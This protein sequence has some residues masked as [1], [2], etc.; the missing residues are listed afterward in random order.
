MA[1]AALLRMR[2]GHARMGL[3]LAGALMAAA[4]SSGG[5]APATSSIA[6]TSTTTTAA[7]TTTTAVPTTTS[8]SATT[9]T[10]A[11]LSTTTTGA[12]PTTTTTTLPA[13]WRPVGAEDPLRVWVF[14]DSLAGPV[15]NALARLASAR[16]VVITTIDFLS[17]SG[18]ASPAFYDW[19]EFVAWRLP[20]VAPDVVVTVLGANDGQGMSTAQGWL[21]Y[22]TPEWDAEY[23]ARVG[24]FM[25]QLLT[26][27][28]RVYWVR[29]PIMENPYYDQRIRHMNA[30]IRQQA[31]LRLGIRS[32]EAYTLF[33]DDTGRFAAALPDEQGG[34]VTMRLGDGIHYTSAGAER[35][36]R[37]VLEV[38][39][40][41]WRLAALPDG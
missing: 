14:G 30:I 13:W 8:T 3:V 35:M 18:L 26:A 22:G 38:I 1:R 33:Q 11:P 10:P 37:R 41:D 31:A 40:A 5:E 36:A 4:C 32:V 28:A 15:G 12:L 9:S 21:E 20:Q 24:S 7:S 34:L 25:D 19:P 16:G 39:A 27:S 23:A 6:M 2:H 17:G 29:M